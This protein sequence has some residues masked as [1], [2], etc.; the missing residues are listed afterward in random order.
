[1]AD[2]GGF[3]ATKIEPQGEYKPF[4]AGEYRMVIVKSEKKQNSKKNGFYLEMVFQVIEGP[5]KGRKAISR[6]NIWNPSEVATR[7][8]NSELSA[9]CHATGVMQPRASEQLHDIPMVVGIEIEERSDKA[10]Q[11]NNVPKTFKKVGTVG[12]QSTAETV[13]AGPPEKAPWE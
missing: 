6:L 13:P 7:I 12:S 3:D 2:L 11:F 1:M 10:G 8:A 4:P 5:H 9:I